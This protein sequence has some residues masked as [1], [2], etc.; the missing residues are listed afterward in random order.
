MNAENGLTVL[1]S[2]TRDVGRGIARIDNEMMEKLGLSKDNIIEIKGK[3]RTVARCM[4]PLTG[5]QL[6]V[7]RMQ[8]EQAQKQMRKT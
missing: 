4:S 5:S 3:R 8:L 6:A 7:E 1:E 2:Y